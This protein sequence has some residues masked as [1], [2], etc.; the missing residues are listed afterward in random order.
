M[1]EKQS[2]SKASRRKERIKI[3]EDINEMKNNKSMKPQI[4]SLKRLTNLIAF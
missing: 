2:K 1:Y 3:R 4:G